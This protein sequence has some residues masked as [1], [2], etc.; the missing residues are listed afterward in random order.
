M[1]QEADDQNHVVGKGNLKLCQ[2]CIS[3]FLKLTLRNRVYL[4]LLVELGMI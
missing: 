2:K 4:T 1:R 3:K